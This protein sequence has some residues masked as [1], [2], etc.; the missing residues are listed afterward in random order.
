[1]PALFL[2]L[3]ATTIACRFADSGLPLP[4]DAVHRRLN[5]GR[6][7]GLKLG[8]STFPV[9]PGP[10]TTANNAFVTNDLQKP[11]RILT[12]NDNSLLENLAAF[13]KKTNQEDELCYWAFQ[14]LPPPR[15]EAPFWDVDSGRNDQDIEWV[16]AY[17]E[18]A[19]SRLHS[20]ISPGG[21]T[22]HAMCSMGARIAKRRCDNGRSKPE[23]CIPAITNGTI[24]WP[25]AVSMWKVGH[26]DLH[27]AVQ[28]W[29]GNS[30]TGHFQNI[31][32]V[33]HTPGTTP[34]RPWNGTQPSPGETNPKNEPN[35]FTEWPQSAVAGWGAPKIAKVVKC[36]DV[37]KKFYY[38]VDTLYYCDHV[39]S[40][41][42]K[43]SSVDEAYEVWRSLT[44]VWP[45]TKTCKDDQ[46]GLDSVLK[47]IHMDFLVG[48]N[49]SAVYPVLQQILP[50]FDCDNSD[51]T[52]TLRD[53]CCSV[54]GSN[55]IP[56][57][58]APSPPGD[59]LYRCQVCNH[60][61]NAERDGGGKAFEALPDTWRCP[62]CGAPKSAYYK[63]ASGEWV[64]AD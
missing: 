21:P 30:M 29:R 32:W 59:A 23:K 4:A 27:S 41:S 48:Q 53:M 15:G 60:V 1:M 47:A 35:G 36:S 64:H 37:P 61:Y 58:P 46:E 63:Q 52:P 43:Q 50:N 6:G 39:E 51:T 5:L 31:G 34:A 26:E 10:V 25:M 19:V 28:D 24:Q 22:V 38:N 42:A 20:R 3:L 62:I 49:C 56:D 33:V 8:D 13:A 9:L 18:V 55:R 7:N 40:P 12:G 54:C 45:P 2:A 16:Q 17:G 44:G 14:G 11:L 57:V